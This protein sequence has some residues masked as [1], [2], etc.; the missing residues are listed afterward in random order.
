[1]Y[2]LR[3]AA[4]EV[5]VT[6]YQGSCARS[7]IATM[8]AVSTAPLGN[9]QTRFVARRISRSTNPAAIVA[10]ASPLSAPTP[11]CGAAIATKATR[12]IVSRPFG[13][14]KKL[15]TLPVLCLRPMAE[16]SRFVA[17]QF[18]RY[19]QSAHTHAIQ[20]LNAGFRAEHERGRRQAVR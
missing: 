18:R 15:L 19:D 2:L 13:V 6:T 16:A 14:L 3:I 10:L 12:M 1:M 20:E 4:I 9:S 5:M 17:L 8:M 7:T 11:S